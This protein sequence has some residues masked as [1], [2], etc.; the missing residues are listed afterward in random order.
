MIIQ[1]YT[2]ESEVQSPK[3]QMVHVP[4]QRPKTY[5]C[6]GLCKV[7]TRL[8]RRR[9]VYYTN[10]TNGLTLIRKKAC[11]LLSSKGMRQLPPHS[12]TEVW[13]NLLQLRGRTSNPNPGSTETHSITKDIRKNKYCK[14]QKIK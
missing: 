11:S 4:Y 2:P 5:Q 3:H 13:V 7:Q 10:P 1:I 9:N 6:H 8:D 12:L 14:K